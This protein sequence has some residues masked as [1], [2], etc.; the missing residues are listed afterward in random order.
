MISALLRIVNPLRWEIGHIAYFQEVWCLRHFLGR[1][2][3]LENSD[4]LYDSALVHHETR[5]DLPLPSRQDTLNFMRH[6]LKSVIELNQASTNKPILRYGRNYFLQL[7]LFHEQMH[8]EAIAYTRR[9]L[10]YCAP[11]FTNPT[12]AASGKQS[13]SR[14]EGDA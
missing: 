12:R 13:E 11:R 9:T 8:A 5:W 2:P 4:R 1:E 3:I 7:T 14:L 10:S 6:M